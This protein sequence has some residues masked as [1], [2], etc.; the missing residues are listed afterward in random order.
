VFLATAVRKDGEEIQWTPG[1]RYSLLI[2]TR[3]PEG[4]AADEPLARMS[5][6][7]AGWTHIKLER[8]KRL[9]V[10]SVPGGDVLRAAFNEALVDGSSVVAYQEPLR[11][12]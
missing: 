10:T 3:M 11:H 4:Q 6:S 1:S 2:F 12:F 9:A 7:S 5:A 8:V